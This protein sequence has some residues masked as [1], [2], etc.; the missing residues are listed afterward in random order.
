MV[1]AQLPIPENARTEQS[2]AGRFK[3]KREC[4]GGSGSEGETTLLRGD[5]VLT[6]AARVRLGSAFRSSS[7]L[8]GGWSTAVAPR[9]WPWSTATL[10]AP[11]P[12][13]QASGITGGRLA[14]P[15]RYRPPAFQ[16][17][18]ADDDD[19]Q[20]PPGPPQSSRHQRP[21]LRALALGTLPLVDHRVPNVRGIHS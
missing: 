16:W 9:P 11:H 8:R 4:R 3:K 1:A 17:C 5:I 7:S 14:P 19:A 21:C 18:C 12:I 15:S 2:P 6:A 20:R 10:L 13:A